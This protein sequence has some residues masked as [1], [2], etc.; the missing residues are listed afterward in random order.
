MTSTQILEELY[1]RLP[2]RE[3]DRLIDSILDQKPGSLEEAEVFLSGGAKVNTNKSYN[4]FQGIAE[5]PIYKTVTKFMSGE[6]E[7]PLQICKMLSSIITQIFIQCEIRGLNSSQFDLQPI[8]TV[9]QNISD[10]GDT[11][12]GD[13]LIEIQNIIEALGWKEK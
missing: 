10:A 12:D 1:S 2:S 7:N 3:A 5:K 4:L 11:I 8:F 9:I 13:I 6:L